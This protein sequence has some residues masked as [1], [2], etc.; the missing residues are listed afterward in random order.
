MPLWRIQLSEVRFINMPIMPI[1]NPG[2]MIWLSVLPLSVQKTGTGNQTWPW[3]IR[4]PKLQTPRTCL[5][6]IIWSMPVVGTAKDIPWGAC[7]LFSIRDWSTIQAFL[8]LSMRAE[9]LL[10]QF[11]S[12]VQI[13]IIW[14]MRDRLIRS[15]PEDG[16]IHSVGKIFHWM[17]SSLS[18]PAIKS[19]WLRHLRPAIANWTQCRV[20]FLTVGC[21]PG[22]KNIPTCLLLSM[23]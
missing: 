6:F 20:S 22:M 13:W 21:N 12:R 18:K 19:V 16:R 2:V 11:I 1:W 5:L 17:C 3:G 15:I 23:C 9:W 10:I 4:Q 14:S 8:C 7:F